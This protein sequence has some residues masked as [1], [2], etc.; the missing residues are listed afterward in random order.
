MGDRAQ[1]I[2]KTM[3]NGNKNVSKDIIISYCENLIKLNQED[4]A[5]SFIKKIVT[6]ASNDDVETV[7]RH[8]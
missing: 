1:K 2:I 3:S 4:K 5:I 6:N 8:D 7:I